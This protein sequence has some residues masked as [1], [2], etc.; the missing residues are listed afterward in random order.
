M[1]PCARLAAIVDTVRDFITEQWLTNRGSRS[2]E[3][4]ARDA[5]FI[6]FATENTREC[7]EKAMRNLLEEMR[8]LSQYFG[9]Y[10]DDQR[11]LQGLIDAMFEETQ[12]ALLVRRRDESLLT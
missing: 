4:F 12:T 10:C 5:R 9:S 2:E 7:S 1:S 6:E 3:I 11:K 8:G